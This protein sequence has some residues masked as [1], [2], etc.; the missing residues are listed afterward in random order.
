[1]KRQLVQNLT[2]AALAIFGIQTASAHIGYGSRD[3]GIVPANGFKDPITL[4]ATTRLYGWA[5]GTDA[6]FGDSHK[7]RAFKF[8]LLSSS[9]IT[10]TVQATGVSN[11]FLPAFSIFS[12]LALSGSH[13]FSAETQAY[14]LATYGSYIY[15]ATHL[16]GTYDGAY[17][18]LNDWL[19]HNDAG[20]ASFFTHKGNAADGT[21]TNYGSASGING[22]GLADG[23]V[24]ASFWLP[25][26][27]YSVFVGGADYD[28]DQ[29]STAGFSATFSAVPEPSSSLLL[30]LGAGAVALRKRLRAKPPLKINA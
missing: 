10:L 14:F 20:N 27:D 7:T 13:D 29:S 19:I 15:D 8:T 17:R 1:M 23:F 4:T 11:P 16:T 6:D 22:D 5:D 9:L 21:A 26:G 30:L 28:A 18:S 24:T 25:A 3:F 2:L 12:G